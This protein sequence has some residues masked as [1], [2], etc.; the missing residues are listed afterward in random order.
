MNVHKIRQDFPI[1]QRTVNDKPL[2]YLDNAATTQRPLQVIQA[3]GNFYRTHN[4]NVHRSPHTL[5]FEATQAYED[6]HRAVA[7]LINAPSWRE[8]I[9]VRNATEALNLVAYGWGLHHLKEGD[10]ILT[11]VSEHHS[12]IVPWQF[13]ARVTGARVR[14]V[15]VDEEGRWTPDDVRKMLSPHT[16]I[17]ALGHVSNITGV[18]HPVK[19]AAQLAR[20][21]GALVVVDGAQAVPHLPVDVQDLGVDFYAASG[22]KMLGPTGIG[23]LWGRA[24]LLE[25]MEP[26]LYGGDM[27][28]EVTLEGASWNEL[29]WKFEAGT[30]N[31]AGGIGL[32]AAVDYLEAVGLQAILEHELDLTRYALERLQEI[33]GIVLYGPRT[34]ENRVG[35]ITFNLEGVHPHDVAY[36]LDQ[37]GIAIRSGHHCAQPLLTRLAAGNTARASFYLYNTR[38]EVDLFITALEK[39]ARVLR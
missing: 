8:V 19:E 39:A 3:V 22:H 7:R 20:E 28:A 38:D 4:A 12:N 26:F 10:E 32:K 14:Y 30:P 18:I 24:E 25:S 9:F 5:S 27:I 6:A 13:L 23:F 17:V 35:V 36:I 1:L 37:E 34:A 2:V 21:A 11:T 29:P 15:P 16:R 31:I 33:P